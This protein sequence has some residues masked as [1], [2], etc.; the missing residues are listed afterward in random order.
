MAVVRSGE[1]EMDREMLKWNKP[2]KYEPFPRMI[3]RGV[4]R[5][6]GVHDF[7]QKIVDS[8]RQFTEAL[9]D[10]WVES[11]ADAKAVVSAQESAIAE[12]AAENAHAAQ[13][14]SAKA[15][16]ELALREAAT[17]RHVAE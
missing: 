13:K 15:R 2:Y 10:G 3:Y 5:S 1:T 14:M 11:P 9:R 16:K 7:E 12:A 17:H 6:D 4:L 8:E